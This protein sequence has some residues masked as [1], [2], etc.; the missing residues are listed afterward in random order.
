MDPVNGARI[1]FSPCGLGLG[2]I[3]RLHP[4]ALDLKRRGAEILFSTYLEGYDYAVK[5]G[6]PVIR[7]PHL[8][9]E[10]VNGKIDLKLSSATQGLPAIPRFTKQI[11]V[12][13]SY[14]RNF[15]PDIVVSDSRMSSIFAAKFLDI[16]TILILN[17]FQPIVPRSQHNFTLS[18]IA[19]GVLLT[20]VGGGW[21]LSDRILI[22]DFPEPYTLSL[23]SLRIPKRY[24]DHVKLIGSILPIK[25][26]EINNTDRIKTQIG[27]KDDQT[28]IFAALSGP[29]LERLPLIRILKPIFEKFPEEYKIFMSLGMPKEKMF[30]HEYGP[31]ILTPWV[32]NRFEYLKASDIIISRAGHE[33]IMHSICFRKPQIVIP[34]PYHTEQYANARRIKDLG[35]GEAIHQKDISLESLLELVK[36]VSK[37]S[38][39]LERLSEIGSFR[40]HWDGVSNAVNEIINLLKR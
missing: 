18:K 6:F 16:P 24:Q 1:Y 39:Y 25:P 35:V 9:M 40:V 10:T 22:P 26:E 29:E 32:P 11:N 14:M 30:F 17:Q 31:L 4:I 36:T 34:T 38:K 33:T 28:L 21:A 27:L 13:I 2:H 7:S 3:G 15:K 12:E 20:V 8:N 23:E 19:D 5:H 37:N